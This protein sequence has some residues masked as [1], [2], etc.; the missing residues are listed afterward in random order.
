MFECGV[1]T[2]SKSKEMT[3]NVREITLEIKPEVEEK[4]NTKYQVFEPI[5]YKSFLHQ[6]FD[7]QVE[8][9]IGNNQ[10]LHVTIHNSFKD[11]KEV[12]EITD[13]KVHSGDHHEQN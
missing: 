12:T 3:D 2:W 10:H 13:I 5:S 1:G 11:D 7:Y 8:V 6:R 9:N 4:T